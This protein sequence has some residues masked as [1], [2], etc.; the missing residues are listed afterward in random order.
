[1]TVIVKIVQVHIE[2]LWF[3]AMLAKSNMK[4]IL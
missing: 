2:Y 1:M 3:G 4:H